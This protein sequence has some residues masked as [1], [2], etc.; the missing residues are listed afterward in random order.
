MLHEITPIGQHDFMYVA[1]RHKTEFNYPLHHHEVFELNF[2]ENGRGFRRVVGD[3]DEIVNDDID[4]VLITSQGVEHE[5]A[6]GDCQ[7]EDIHEVTVQFYL[8]IN[9]PIFQTN[10][11]K[12]IHTMLERAQRGLAF[13]KQAI[14]RV[15]NDL[16]G[17]SSINERFYA[18][19]KLFA[20]LYELSKAVNSRELA[21][22]S[23]AKV[24]IANDESR[25]VRR[26][27]NYINEHFWEDIRL[28]KLCE[29]CAMT[30]SAFSRFFKERTGK[31]VAEYIVDIR[32][33]HAARELVDTIK[34]VSEI[35][36]ESGFSTLSNF[37]RLFR[38]RKNCSPTEFRQKYVKTKVII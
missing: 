23:Y 14:M 20:I 26:V 32:L 21:S 9:S 2:I 3:C 25:R 10:P 30:P 35:A 19:H 24:P 37:N 29:M 27:K 4:L 18:V 11:F 7:S 17:L 15:Y 8:D 34:P 28:A 33:G 22:S 38:K 13:P 1:D 36:Y 31:A 5:W 16:I 6:Q 12:S